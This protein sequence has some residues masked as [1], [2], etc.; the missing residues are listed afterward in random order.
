MCNNWIEVD[1]K[2]K[3]IEESV[4][5]HEN[6]HIREK[7]VFTDQIINMLSQNTPN[8]QANVSSVWYSEC[9]LP[10]YDLENAIGE[11]TAFKCEIIC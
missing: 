5:M 4:F 3:W 10:T 6:R 2:I 8:S 7:L 11:S 1:I 9:I